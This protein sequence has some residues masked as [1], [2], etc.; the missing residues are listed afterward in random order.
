MYVNGRLVKSL[1]ER[2]LEIVIYLLQHGSATVPELKQR[3][4]KRN[5]DEEEVKD[6]TV[7]NTLYK[8]SAKTIEYG[9]EILSENKEYKI[10][11]HPHSGDKKT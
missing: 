7:M 10:S 2:D 3:F 11:P 8:I 4:W 1:Q 9:F 5:G 6:K